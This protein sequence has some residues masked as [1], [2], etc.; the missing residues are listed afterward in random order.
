MAIDFFGVRLAGRIR[1]FAANSGSGTGRVVD[2]WTENQDSELTKDLG[3]LAFVSE[4][5]VKY[6][7][8]ENAEISLV[9]TPPFEDALKFMQSEL[10]RFG[11]GRLEVEL[12]YT[13]G[14]F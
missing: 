6:K 13:T 8:G 12:G 9:L 4:V 14:T 1:Q 5:N 3:A 10:V 11:T 7:L 2:L